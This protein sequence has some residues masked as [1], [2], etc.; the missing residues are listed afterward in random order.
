MAEPL[1]SVRNLTV[2]Y[3]VPGHPGQSAVAVDGVDLELSAGE[4][5]GLVGE[6][7]CGK[8]SLARALTGTERSSGEVLVGGQ[9]LADRPARE[10]ARQVQLVF[11]DP[12]ESLNPRMSVRACLAEPIR[13]H[14]LAPR[15][16]VD[17]RVRELV[18]LV[19]LPGQRAGRAAARAVGRAAPAGRDRPGAGPGA[20]GDDRR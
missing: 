6:S 3:P 18:D 20:A 5:L 17:T 14:R 4:A 10:R 1:L 9:R 7:G 16:A 15:P 11:Q 12:Y 19:G 2:A 13:V 8:S